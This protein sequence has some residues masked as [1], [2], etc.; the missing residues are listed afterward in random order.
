[1]QSVRTLRGSQ[2]AQTRERVRALCPGG[3][4]ATT[5]DHLRIEA[6]PASAA[7][8]Q[9]LGEGA[10]RILDGYRDETVPS[11][12][13]EV[14][15]AIA[16]LVIG[17]AGTAPGVPQLGPPVL[18][19]VPALLAERRITAVCAARQGTT[20]RLARG[21]DA[22][23][24]A[25]QAMPTAPQGMLSFRRSGADTA[26]LVL[27]SG[28][29]ARSRVAALRRMVA[30]VPGSALAQADYRSTQRTELTVARRADIPA[31]LRAIAAHKGGE[32][33]A[34]GP[35]LRIG[36]TEEQATRALALLPAIERTGMRATAFFA[37]YQAG[38]D[39]TWHVHGDSAALRRL[40]SADLAAAGF[41]AKATVLMAARTTG[42]GAVTSALGAD[43]AHTAPLLADLWDAGWADARL[44]G[45]ASSPDFTLDVGSSPASQTAPDPVRDPGRARF[46]RILRGSGWTGTAT[47]RVAQLSALSFDSTATGRA[48]GARQAAAASGVGLDD[49]ARSFVDAWNASAA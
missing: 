35:G 3:A 17:P 1:M 28:A 32:G 41:D 42:A 31:A 29:E 13:I 49:G 48:Q 22:L 14:G 18:A 9:A 11:A 27:P 34:N 2:A 6:R 25:P 38:K 40:G 24:V 4:T 19:D 43:R 12:A 30:A 8:A 33:Q 16:P 7:A 20:A 39:S 46:I 44:A 5:G 15:R 36:G 10:Y 26:Q 23:N 47:I 21:A 37:G 45:T